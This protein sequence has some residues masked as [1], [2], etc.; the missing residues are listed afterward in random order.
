[1][2]FNIINYQGQF[3]MHCKTE[4]EARSFCD[5]LHSMGR[6]WC[7]GKSY[8]DS[9]NYHVHGKHTVY[10][11]NDGSY[12]STEMCYN[13]GYKI[14]EWSDFTTHEF[15]KSALKTGDI[16]LCRN[17]EVGIVN[18]ELE[19]IVIKND[20]LDLNMFLEDLSHV[21]MSAWNI[22]AVRRPTERHHCQFSAFEKE[23][24]ELVYERKGP[25]EMTLEEVCKALGKE[26]K[27]V[28]KK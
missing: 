13:Y 10:F 4:K 22:V 3:A 25:E 21:Q 2:K 28:E 20:W 6:R 16:I 26:I 14:L 27:I 9:T 19:I 12:G 5:Y 7:T 23:Y 24:G 17:E 11:F 15:G 18:R 1:M 8:K